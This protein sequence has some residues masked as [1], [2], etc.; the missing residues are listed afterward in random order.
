MQSTLRPYLTTGVAIVGASVIAVAPLSIPPAHLPTLNIASVVQTATGGVELNGGVELTA[1]ADISGTLN[2][3]VNAGLAGIA[4]SLDLEGSV[5]I[6]AD[7]ATNFT[8]LVG[9]VI[10]Q[11]STAFGV[12]PIAAL[13]DLVMLPVNVVTGFVNGLLGVITGDPLGGLLGGLGDLVTRPVELITGLF[14]DLVGDVTPA[15]LVDTLGQLIAA[16]IRFTLDALQAGNELLAGLVTGGIEFGATAVTTALT[17]GSEFLGAAITTGAGFVG[18]LFTGAGTLLTTGAQAVLAALAPLGELPVVG[19]VFMAVGDVVAGFVTAGATVLDGIGTGIE[20]GAAVLTQLISDTVTLVNTAINGGAGLLTGVVTVGSTAVDD[21]LTGFQNAVTDIFG[22]PPEMTET[23]DL[24]D[25]A[26]SVLAAT[27]AATA[28]AG[29]TSLPS[30]SPTTVTLP[31]RASVTAEV[32]TSESV[33]VDLPP[34]ASARAEV[35]TSAAGTVTVPESASPTA[36][37][38]ADVINST[39]SAGA[40]FGKEV[41]AAATGSTG[42]SDGDSTGTTR[43]SAKA[44]GKATAKS[45]DSGASGKAKGHARSAKE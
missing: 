26:A 33:T 21:V 15:A 24:P 4:L 20:G 39:T 18:G 10:D 28:S 31:T 27:R 40:D 1:L 11:I 12:D 23:T 19:P 34:T 29:I 5:D 16:P 30:A 32:A 17:A 42:A 25:S 37:A 38:V 13:R 9:A 44:A 7:L 3:L 22:P 41:S 36:G 2:A 14:G 8:S 35:A 43:G 45:G 6:E